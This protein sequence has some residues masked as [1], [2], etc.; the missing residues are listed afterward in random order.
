MFKLHLCPFVEIELVLQQSEM[1]ILKNSNILAP[2]RQHFCKKY[3]EICLPFGV[4]EKDV[5]ENNSQKKSFYH[6]D[7]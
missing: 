6:Q 1:Q 5:A 7:H 2:K 3:F 4:M